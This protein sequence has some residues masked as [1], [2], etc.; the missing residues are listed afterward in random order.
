MRSTKQTISPGGKTPPSPEGK[1]KRP[2]ESR[3]AVGATET[4]PP[5]TILLLVPSAHTSST[6]LRLLATLQIHHAVITLDVDPDRSGAAHGTIAG[7]LMAVMYYGLVYSIAEMS[8]ALP[9][10]GG[11]YSFAR[12]AMGPW[13]GFLTG[14]AENMEYVFTPAVIEVS[15]ATVA[16]SFLATGG[17]LTGV[18]VMVSVAESVPP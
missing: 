2:P 13:G 1:K 14:L 7:I 11:A 5:G 15:S 18:T 12:S 9:H 3:R 8:P 16:T 6:D 17:S 10:T 4:H